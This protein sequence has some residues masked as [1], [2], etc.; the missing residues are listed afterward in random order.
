MWT[1]RRSFQEQKRS[2]DDHRSP[3]ER[4][5]TRVI[6]AAAFRRLQHKTQIHGSGH[7]DFH[8]TRLTHS[9]EVASIAKSLLRNLK[10][11]IPDFQHFPC[12]DLVTTIALLHDIGHPPFGHGGEVA[13]NYLMQDAGGF[14]SN[15]QT[16]RLLT[17][18]ESTYEPY[19]LDLTKRSLLGVLKYPAPYSALKGMKKADSIETAHPPKCFYDEDEL[20]VCWLLESLSTEERAIFQAA[21]S[22]SNHPHKKTRHHS[23][24][25]SL[26]NIA[27]DIAY[28]VHDL[29]DAIVLNLLTREQFQSS[30]FL[31]TC[32]QI[33]SENL[34]VTGE[35]LIN[36]LF[37]Q[38]EAKRK[39]AI[40]VLVNFFITETELSC[41]NSI[42]EPLCAFV[43]KQHPAAEALLDE[44]KTL[45]F[46]TVITSP[47]GKKRE[48]KGQQVLTELFTIAFTKPESIF[49]PEKLRDFHSRNADCD[50]KRYISDALANLTDNSA[51]S[52]YQ[53]LMKETTIDGV[54]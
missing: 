24:D 53:T 48:K 27:D 10:R 8:R 42:Q 17:T 4:D 2:G 1:I 51:N 7:G 32:R 11:R 9:L 45:I 21:R 40:G 46:N 19:G 33:Q 16:L 39:H 44:L 14:E 37:S 26:M 52:L 15:A 29:E 13:L 18:L 30:H 41:Q 28:G 38:N 22:L 6:H 35:N 31:D 12:D 47:Y 43:V 25:C 34:T 49:S 23:L 54:I 36:A 20:I 3:Y 5:N 50:K